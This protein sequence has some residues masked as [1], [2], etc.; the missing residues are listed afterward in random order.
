M[1]S[2]RDLSSKFNEQLRMLGGDDKTGVFEPVHAKTL[3]NEVFKS[4]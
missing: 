2:V 1:P 4:L 3:C